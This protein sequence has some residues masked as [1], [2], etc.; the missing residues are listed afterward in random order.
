MGTVH[1]YEAASVSPSTNAYYSA[2]SNLSG[3]DINAVRLQK[4]SLGAFADSIATYCNFS[5]AE[6]ITCLTTMEIEERAD[7]VYNTL[8]KKVRKK[9]AGKI[10]IR[11]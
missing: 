6:Q 8:L 7:F 3:G 5:R 11:I 9:G 1:Y 2:V 4:E 10:P